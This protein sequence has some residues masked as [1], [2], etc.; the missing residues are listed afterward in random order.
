MAEVRITAT[1]IFPAHA[2]LLDRLVQHLL[3]RFGDRVQLQDADRHD[4]D[5]QGQHQGEAKRKALPDLHIR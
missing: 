1:A 3:G 4:E 2:L 5:R